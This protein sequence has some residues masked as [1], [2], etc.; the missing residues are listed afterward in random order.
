MFGFAAIDQA[1]APVYLLVAL[2]LLDQFAWSRR[3]LSEF[4]ISEYPKPETANEDMASPDSTTADAVVDVPIVSFEAA[5]QKTRT[6]AFAN[7]FSGM[8]LLL[9]YAG[10]CLAR[11]LV[12]FYASTLWDIQTL[13]FQFIASRLLLSALW[14]L[15]SVRFCPRLIRV[16][17]DERAHLFSARALLPMILPG[18]LSI[19][20]ALFVMGL[21]I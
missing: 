2:F 5:W 6:A 18:G 16:S 9:L 3:W 10:V 19:L 14:S 4:V 15:L 7:C 13:F 20:L 12:A 17:T 8:I 21:L 11:I 1:I